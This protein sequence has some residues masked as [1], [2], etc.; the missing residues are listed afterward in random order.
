MSKKDWSYVQLAG[1]TA[2]ALVAIHGATS[3]NWRDLHTLG[4]ILCA[5]AAVGPELTRAY[6][7]S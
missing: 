3:R 1:M 5:V 6:P 4:V 2:L 7:S